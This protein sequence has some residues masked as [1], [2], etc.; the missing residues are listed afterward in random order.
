MTHCALASF[1]FFLLPQSRFEL[2]IFR[3][4]GIELIRICSGFLLGR[5]SF[6]RTDV[7][8]QSAIHPVFEPEIPPESHPFPPDVNE[9]CLAGPPTSSGQRGDKPM[10]LRRRQPYAPLGASD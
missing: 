2:K 3:C 7:R 10:N 1:S 6:P 4:G 9:V 8:S 5:S